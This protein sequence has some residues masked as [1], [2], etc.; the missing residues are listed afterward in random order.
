ML[1]RL[2][3]R[4]KL[5]MVVNN[6][7]RAF[8]ASAVT[9]KKPSIGDA[10][11]ILQSKVSSIN[12]VVSNILCLLVAVFVSTNISSYLKYRMTSRS[13]ELSS[14]LEMVLQESSDL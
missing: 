1:S 3:Q 7:V 14:L 6:A 11:T 13:S 10:V 2:V 8:R 9:D 12:Q 5:P 4:N